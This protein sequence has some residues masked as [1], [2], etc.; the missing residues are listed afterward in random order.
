LDVDVPDGLPLG[1]A[2]SRLAGGVDDFPS[3]GRPTG[4]FVL[5]MV[6]DGVSVA[7][8][9]VHHHQAVPTTTV[10]VGHN[11]PIASE[12]GLACLFVEEPLAAA[13]NV[14]DVEVIFAAYIVMDGEK[15]LAPQS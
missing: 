13:I 9:A 15:D 6:G 1:A 7:P 11:K 3:I 4:L 5:R 14:G 10:A 8:I 12:L 2:P